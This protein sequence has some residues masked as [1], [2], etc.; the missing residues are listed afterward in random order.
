MLPKIHPLTKTF[1]EL[2]RCET[3]IDDFI[4][5]FPEGADNEVERF[6]RLYNAIQTAKELIPD[7]FRRA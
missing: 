7:E 2:Q 1:T 4:A 3:R 5:R 6:L